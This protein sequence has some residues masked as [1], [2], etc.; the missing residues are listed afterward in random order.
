MFL[1]SLK[2]ILYSWQSRLPLLLR[3]YRTDLELH[4]DG[5]LN[6]ETEGRRLITVLSLFGRALYGVYAVAHTSDRS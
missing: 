6:P 5:G 3:N 2:S 1:S 4:D